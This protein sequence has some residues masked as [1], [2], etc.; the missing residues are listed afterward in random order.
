MPTRPPLPRRLARGGR[1]TVWL[2]AHPDGSA[3]LRRAAGTVQVRPPTPKGWIDDAA[4][5]GNHLL[6]VE[7]RVTS[8]D[9]YESRVVHHDLAKGPTSDAASWAQHKG[10]AVVSWLVPHGTQ[11]AWVPPFGREPGEQVLSVYGSRTGSVRQR[12]DHLLEQGGQP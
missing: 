7:M 2:R 4:L 9:E 10:E 5:V 3:S 6:T 8:S 1:R 11:I 12:H